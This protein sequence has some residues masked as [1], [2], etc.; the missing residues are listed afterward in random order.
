MSPAKSLYTDEDS[1]IIIGAGTCGASTALELKKTFPLQ[2]DAIFHDAY[3]EGITHVYLNPQSGWGEGRRALKS[4]VEAAIAHG[5]YFNQAPISAL[6]FDEHNNCQGVELQ[7]GENLT[8][9]HIVAGTGAWT[10]CFLAETASQRKDVQSRDR[11][12]TA[13]AIQRQASFDPDEYE[14][15]GLAPVIF[16]AM[17]HTKGASILTTNDGKMKFNFEASFTNNTLHDK[18]G[19]D[20]FR[21]ASEVISDYMESGCATGTQR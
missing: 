19:Q 10:L 8:A 20:L 1:N 13:G 17:H 5:A 3:W 21:A 12:V 14:K 4:L 15:L 7:D 11:I 6:T 9:R 2:F 16:N 18:S